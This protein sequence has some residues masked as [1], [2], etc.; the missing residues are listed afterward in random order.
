MTYPDDRTFRDQ[1]HYIVGL[2][3]KGK[4]VTY[5]Q[6]SALAGVPRGARMVGSVAHWGDP[7]IPWQRVVNRNGRVAPGWPGGMLGHK[8]ALEAEGI[9]V[10]EDFTVDRKRYQWH[11]SEQLLDTLEL[12]PEALVRLEEL[13]P[14]AKRT[15]T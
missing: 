8:A 11:P 5:G 2:V 13:I 9:E 1:V 10:R 7:K 4:V 3:P 12:P 15:K 6:V 14:Y